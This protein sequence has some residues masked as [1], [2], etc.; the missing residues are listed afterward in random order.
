[1]TEGCTSCRKSPPEVVLKRCA[2]CSTT[3]YCSRDCQKA[4]W[5][6]HKKICG[7][8]ADARSSAADGSA[9]A[10][11]SPPKGLEKGVDHPFTRL[12]NGTWLYDRSEKDVYGLLIDAYR[13]RVE[14]LYNMEGEAEADSIYGGAPNGLHGFQRFLKK[15]ASRPGLLPPW[16]D[17]TKKR[18]CEKLGMTTGQWFDLGQ[19]VN[20]SDIIE[21][22]GDS[23]FPMQLRMFAEAV[24]GRVPGGTNGSAMRQ[25][26]VAMEQGRAGNVMTSA[27][28]MSS[29]FRR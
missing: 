11:L 1:M 15:V 13:L 24:Y 12:E 22:Y 8:R 9:A 4:D 28:D 18:D 14:D 19:A 16:W 5:K 6:G 10:K 7:G 29:V 21:N 27:M 17:A 20:K 25:L 2:K 26:M 3:T 23:Q